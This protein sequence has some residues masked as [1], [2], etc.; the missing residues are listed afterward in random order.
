M[1]E[2]NKSLFNILRIVGPG[3]FFAVIFAVLYSFTDLGLYIS[4]GI[5]LVVAVLDYIV[6]TF[7]MT[8]LGNPSE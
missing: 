7:I 8:R 1:H 3:L 2:S 4:L 6:L 5:A